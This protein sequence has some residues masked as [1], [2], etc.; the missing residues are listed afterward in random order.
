MKNVL[1]Y[2]KTLDGV[3]NHTVLPAIV[4]RRYR[5]LRIDVTARAAGVAKVTVG[6]DANDTRILHQAL[7]VNRGF[8]FDLGGPLD[9]PLN[10]AVKVTTTSAMEVVIHYYCEGEGYALPVIEYAGT[11]FAWTN[12]VAIPAAAVTVV[13]ECGPIDSYAEVGTVLAD[14]GIAVNPTTGEITGTPNDVLAA[15]DIVIRA[16]GP[17][18]TGDATINVTI[19]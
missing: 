1:R 4:T 12:G 6:N 3:S 16:T 2:A 7:A 5:I 17:G 8:S 19:T 13:V 9:L 11:P 14:L 18:G 10:T 15:T